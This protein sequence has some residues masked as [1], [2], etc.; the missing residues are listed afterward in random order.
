MYV[1]VDPNSKRD[2]PYASIIA[3]NSNYNALR[4]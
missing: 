2:N 1:K 3:K 4:L